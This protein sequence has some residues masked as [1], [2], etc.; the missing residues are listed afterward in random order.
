MIPSYYWKKTDVD[1]YRNKLKIEIRNPKPGSIVYLSR[2]KFIS[3][4]VDRIYPSRAISNLILG[5]GGRLFDTK[6]ASPS[7]FFDI[8]RNVETIVADQ[9]S[10]IFGVLQWRSKHVIEVTTD[11]WWHN[12]NLFF[13]K[14]SGVE[15][16]S[17]VVCDN[18][19][20]QEVV[21]SVASL[22][23]NYEKLVPISAVKPM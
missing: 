21:E 5:L 11:R 8:S 14:S 19:T 3:E 6:F 17:V 1:L 4:I 22:I 15:K 23:S 20:D 18:K 7:E 12:A 16:Y 10:A 2:E 9:G 13:S